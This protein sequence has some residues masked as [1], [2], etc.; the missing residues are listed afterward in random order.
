VLLRAGVAAL[1]MLLGLATTVA[2]PRV[3]SQQPFAVVPEAF[4][5]SQ[6]GYC[7][8]VRYRQSV[9]DGYVVKADGRAAAA[10]AVLSAREW[11]G[12]LT[13][14]APADG[15]HDASE[16]NSDE[17]RTV[18]QFRLHGWPLRCFYAG[19]AAAGARSR[20]TVRL[21]FNIQEPSALPFS[22][23][24]LMLW[25]L[26]L[27]T[28]ILGSGWCVLLVAPPLVFGSLRRR[29]RR[30]RGCCSYCGYSRARLRADAMCPECGKGAGTT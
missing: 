3:W 18:A 14:A 4:R 6:A 12:L 27:N 20:G 13:T 9:T 8:V 24:Q 22:S 30:S 2:I 29:Y 1:S 17:D 23:G 28:V 19:Y 16:L 15:T 11:A 7:E 25:P 21:I 5:S 10:R 26:F